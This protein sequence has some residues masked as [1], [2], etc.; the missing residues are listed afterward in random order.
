MPPKFQP[1][2]GGFGRR[3]T[4][5]GDLVGQPLANMRKAGKPG[6]AAH[7]ENDEFQ[8]DNQREIVDDF[9]LGVD[10]MRGF[11]QDQV[12]PQDQA[13]ALLAASDAGMPLAAGAIVRTGDFFYLLRAELRFPIAGDVQGGVFTDIGNVW[14]DADA[15][16]PDQ[17][18][19]LRYTAG[20]GL[21]LA[22][23]VGPI[24]LDYGF[25]LS[26][27]ERLGEP[28]GDR[29]QR[30]AVG[31]AL[32][33]GVVAGRP[34]RHREPHLFCRMRRPDEVEQRRRGERG[35]LGVALLADVLLLELRPVDEAPL[36]FTRAAPRPRRRG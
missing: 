32:E 3:Q 29:L 4:P 21:R 24:A 13:D 30:P 14:A 19:R 7:N 17:L 35:V 26:Q 36:H 33:V 31:V 23:P 10:T 27:N 16:T 12:I 8:Q 28:F 11:L 1:Q 18:I 2:P 5:V 15:L 25:N 6:A 34:G 20:L 9:P 22:T